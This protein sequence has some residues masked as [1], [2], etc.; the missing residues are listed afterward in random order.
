MA[1]G[2]LVTGAAVAGEVVLA[3]GVGVVVSAAGFDEPQAV[4]MPSAAMP[5]ASP[6][7][8]RF[9]GSVS[10]ELMVESPPQ[11][12]SLAVSHPPDILRYPQ[13]TLRRLCCQ[14]GA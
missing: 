5:T 13:D 2:V 12:A 7:R 10:V 9:T 8:R 6:R 3:G 14:A 1:A 11:A 4:R